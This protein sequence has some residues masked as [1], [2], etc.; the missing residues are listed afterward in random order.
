MIMQRVSS[1]NLVAVG[2]DDSIN[3][4]FIQFKI[5]TYKYFDV[6]QNIY[7]NLL[8]ASSKGEYHASYIK[9]NYRYQR[10]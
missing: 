8:N 5:G 6:P 3:T 1:R 10:I 9:D 4:L 7:R 2:Y